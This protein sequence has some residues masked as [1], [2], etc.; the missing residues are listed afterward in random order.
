VIFKLLSAFK[1]SKYCVYSAFCPACPISFC[2]LGLFPQAAKTTAATPNNFFHLFPS[3]V[4]LSIAFKNLN[5]IIFTI[6]I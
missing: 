2:V 1:V 5:C 6:L 3:F 4:I